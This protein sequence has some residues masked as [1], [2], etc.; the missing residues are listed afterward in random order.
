MT[1]A[2]GRFQSLIE[3]EPDTIIKAIKKDMPNAHKEMVM[4]TLDR[5]GF[6]ESVYGDDNHY[7]FSVSSNIEFEA[8]SKAFYKAGYISPTPENVLTYTINHLE[9]LNIQVTLTDNVIDIYEENPTVEYVARSISNFLEWNDIKEILMKDYK[10]DLEN[11]AI[12]IMA[13]DN[14]FPSR[15]VIEQS[16]F[17]LEYDVKDLKLRISEESVADML[18]EE[19][20]QHGR[21]YPYIIDELPYVLIER[22]LV[23]Y[24]IDILNDID[25]FNE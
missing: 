19:I 16:D 25:D 21:V 23:E 13:E 2:G 3:N 18:I 7:I 5:Y 10:H 22:S 6:D 12:T 4:E 15:E 17:T 14:T 24:R 20:K 1:K 9:N 11:D 8:W